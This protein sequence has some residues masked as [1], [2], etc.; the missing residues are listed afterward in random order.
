MFNYV[1]YA[2]LNKKYTSYYIAKVLKNNTIFGIRKQNKGKIEHI[3]NN[4][5]NNIT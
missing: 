5:F 4:V 3:V 2:F 1:K